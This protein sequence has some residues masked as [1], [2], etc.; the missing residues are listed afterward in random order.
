MLVARYTGGAT[1]AYAG[2]TFWQT[3]EPSVR[4]SGKFGVVDHWAPTPE[5][6]AWFEQELSKILAPDLQDQRDV[7]K[8]RKNK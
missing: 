1:T 8:K 6:S 5:Q 3:L 2:E 4:I 7:A